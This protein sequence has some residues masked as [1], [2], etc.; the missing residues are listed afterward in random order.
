MESILRISRIALLIGCSWGTFSRAP[1]LRAQKGIPPEK[2]PPALRGM[3]LDRLS[4]GTYWAITAGAGVVRWPEPQTGR[5]LTSGL[6]QVRATAVLDPKVGLN[7]RF[8]E[9]PPNLP[10]DRRAQAEPHVA[11][12]FRD[13]NLVV[14]TFQ[15]G[16][17]EDYGAVDCGYAISHDGGLTWTRALIPH[18]TKLAGGPFE[19]ASDP[20]VGVDLQNNVFINTIGLQGP[21][22]VT[23]VISK[24]VD[25][26]TTFSE[27]LAVFTP[28]T[29]NA[30]PDKNWMAINTFPGT[31]TA[32]RIAVT[33]TYF[34]RTNV[35]PFPSQVLITPI[36]STYSDNSGQTWSPIRVISPL[37]CQGSQPVFLPDGTLA[38]V[39][40]NFWSNPSLNAG[41]EHIE[42]VLSPDGGQTYGE[43]SL[44]ARVNPYGDGVARN[45][46][47]LPAAT[48]DRQA[49][50]LYV[51]YQ[52]QDKDPQILF[53][54]SIDQ[55]R[56]WSRPVPVNDSPQGVSAFNPAITVSSDGQ[57]VSIMFYDKRNGADANF[58]DLYLAESFDG[59]ET[60]KANLRLSTVSSDL[61][62]APLTPYGRMVGDYQGLVPALSFSAPAVAVW[63]DTRAG[64]PD[65]FSVQIKRTEGATFETWRT[66]RFTTA[67]LANPALSAAQSQ[68][69]GDGLPNLFKYAFGLEPA[70]SEQSP[71]LIAGADSGQNPTM[72][73]TCQRLAV[74]SDLEFSWESSS[75]LVSWQT[76]VPIDLTAG[77]AMD[78]AKEAIMVNVPLGLDPSRFFRVGVAKA[79]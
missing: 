38:V 39:Y 67:E 35:P 10:A 16:R 21:E 62:L 9:D 17:F 26:G 30:F 13:T 63:V 44:V 51:A 41:G 18:L 70:I 19:R 7:I 74:L 54:K 49:G 47:F 73:L 64:S 20:V 8:G 32:G 24:S 78:P 15:E 27:P 11:R 28:P 25:G 68:P 1:V 4:G 72:A 56:T 65:P 55:G 34:I 12:S 57:H 71:L 61:R 42:M 58:V 33:F 60:W 75:D 14:A 59:G 50:V 77:P 3:S 52:A 36:V 69:A 40:W 66:L 29:T 23:V 2:L 5:P 22:S 45:P 48:A 6:A 53:A 79:R 43:P 31:P 76:F 37:N 46:G